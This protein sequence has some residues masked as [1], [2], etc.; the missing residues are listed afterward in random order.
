MLSYKSDKKLKSMMVK[1]MKLHQEQ[2]AIIKGAYGKE[3]G[4]FKGCAVGCAVRSL[5]LKMNKHY[6]YGDHTAY[7]KE[8]GLPEWLARLED[9]IFEGLPDDEAK[10]FPVEFLKSIPVGVNLD[11]VKWKF[12]S[13]ILRENIERVLALTIDE[14]LKKQV[15]DAIRQCLALQEKAIKTG[16]FDESA[17]SAAWSAARS[18][19]WSSESAAYTNYKNELLRLLK[20]AK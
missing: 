3:N 17:E 4:I 16:K 5:N 12:C 10:R 6:A 19:A 8:L 13:F 1:E 18:A 11:S 14:A 20:E 15:V 2:D 9:K 7:E